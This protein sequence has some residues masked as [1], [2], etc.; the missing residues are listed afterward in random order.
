MFY[1]VAEIGGFSGPYLIGAIYDGTGR[2]QVGMG[3]L[4]VLSVVMAVIV[5]M[6]KIKPGR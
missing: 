4:A 2:Y 1:C 3:V 6:L 5:L